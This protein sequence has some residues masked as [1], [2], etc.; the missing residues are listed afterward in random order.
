MRAIYEG[1]DIKVDGQTYS[2]DK[3]QNILTIKDFYTEMKYKPKFN[4]IFCNPFAEI[5]REEN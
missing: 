3:Q 2:Y 4:G 5:I 1:M